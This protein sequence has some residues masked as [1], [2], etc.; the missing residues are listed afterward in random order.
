MHSHYWICPWGW[1]G[2]LGARTSTLAAVKAPPPWPTATRPKP[3]LRSVG[4]Q[5]VVDEAD[6]LIVNTEEEAHQLVSLHHADWARIDVG[7]GGG[8]QTFTPEIG[9]LPR[10]PL[11]LRVPTRG[12]SRSSAV[13]SRS[14][15]R[16]FC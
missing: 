14:R 9:P 16:T 1:P 2:P 5:Q 7:A 15:R 6:R 8:S 4:E 11:G 10:G 3:P 12:S 13:S